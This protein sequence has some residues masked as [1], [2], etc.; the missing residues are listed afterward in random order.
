M[1][2]L[3]T[4]PYQITKEVWDDYYAVQESGVMNMFGYP[5]VVYFLADDSAYDKAFK[6]FEEDGNTE[7]I[8]IE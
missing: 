6:H 2:E 4:K 8:T 5:T 3:P 1:Q 7:P